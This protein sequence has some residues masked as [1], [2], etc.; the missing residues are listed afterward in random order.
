MRI[1][2]VGETVEGTITALQTEGFKIANTAHMMEILSKRLYSNPE[3]AVCRELVCN[4]IDAHVAASNPAPVEITL[5]DWTNDYRFVVKDYGTGLSEEAVMNLYTTYGASTKQSSNDFIGC[6][7]IGSKSPFAVTE[8]FS[9]VSRYKGK[10]TT[11]HC[12]KQKGMPVCTKLSETYTDE[13]DGMTITVPFKEATS[14][15]FNNYAKDFFYG[16]EKA[17]VKV[18]SPQPITFFEDTYNQ[19]KY[20]N[21]NVTLY[22]GSTRYDNDYVRMGQ[23][24]YKIPHSW[25]RQSCVASNYNSLLD[26]PIGTFTI[27]AS[28]ENIEENSDNMNKF[29]QIVTDLRQHYFEEYLE[30]TLKKAKTFYT[31]NKLIRQCALFD[32]MEDI[33]GKFKDYAFSF[34]NSVGYV[35]CWSKSR[36]YKQMRYS[37]E[38]YIYRKEEDSRDRLFVIV[39]DEEPV[40]AIGTLIRKWTGDDDKGFT[41]FMLQ[42]DQRLHLTNKRICRFSFK[43]VFMSQ[44]NKWHAYLQAQQ[45]RR[46]KSCKLPAN[47]SDFV[48][49]E[50]GRDYT[51][52]RRKTYDKVKDLTQVPYVVLKE[53]EPVREDDKPLIESMYRYDCACFGVS[54]TN[55]KGLPPNFIP[56]AD[57]VA[58]HKDD[59]ENK[60]YKE[61]K[62]KALCS[63][64]RAQ[65]YRNSY[66]SSGVKE[67]LGKHLWVSEFDIDDIPI[68]EPKTTGDRMLQ[69]LIEFSRKYKKFLTRVSPWFNMHNYDEAPQEIQSFVKKLLTDIVVSDESTTH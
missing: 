13:H 40:I 38:V 3:L 16:V 50:F 30:P 47:K 60:T 21:G 45:K 61:N 66:I 28:R 41:Y 42:K 20:S 7:G 14:H 9:V 69:S 10:A 68:Y 1:D 22:I 15:T 67:L 27:A 54:L 63:L 57:Y 29:L 43:T 48:V 34:E 59:F 6:L 31:Y 2:N 35:S 5:P 49:Y 56:L 24:C 53:L 23:V 17:K 39:P 55:S 51:F 58:A 19:L 62:H 18:T 11:Y 12:Y 8:E 36:G 4:A 25:I 44:L 46:A 37:S 32:F 52:R 64:K 33:K 26:V 65:R